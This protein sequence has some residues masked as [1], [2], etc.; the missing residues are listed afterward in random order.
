[1]HRLI[2]W[3]MA[4][5]VAIALALLAL[6]AKAD[7]TSNVA[8][9]VVATV[10]SGLT[11][12]V[13]ARLL[14]TR[15]GIGAPKAR[16]AARSTTEV[17]AAGRGGVPIAGVA[18][19]VLNVTVNG[20][21]DSGFLTVWPAGVPRPTASNVNFLPRQT[22]A[23]QAIVKVG[24]GGVI[25]VFSSTST[26]MF[27]DVTGYYPT[28]DGYRAL[29]PSRL[30]DTRP[31]ATRPGNASTT[32]VR[33]LGV[34][35]V[36]ASGVAAVV[37]NVAD[38]DPTNSGWL[39]IFPSGVPRPNASTLNYSGGQARAAMAIA[40]VGTNG[41]VDIYSSSATDLIVDVAGWIPLVS[42]YSAMTPVRVAD[43]RTGAG[44][45]GPVKVGE[46]DAP[47]RTL[48]LPLTG[49]NGIP[50]YGVSA[51]ELNI[52]VTA[53][54]YQGYSTAWPTGVRRPNASTQNFNNADTTRTVANSATVKVGA[55]GSVN[56]FLSTALQKPDTAQIFIDVVGYFR[57]PRTALAID[58][59]PL[60]NGS[61]ALVY[62]DAVAASG[63]RAPYTWSAKGLPSGLQ[64]NPTTGAISGVPTG[65][66]AADAVLTVTD[67]DGTA[68]SRTLSIAVSGGSTLQVKQV[69]AGREHT[70]AVLTNGSVKCWGS[71]R[72]GQLGDGTRNNASTPRTV[73]GLGGGAASVSAGSN[74]TCAL[75]TSGAVRCWG[76]NV[77]GQ[78][79][80]GSTSDSNIP[81]PVTGLTSGTATIS[82]GDYHSCA[83]S[84]SGAAKCWGSNADGRLGNGST[85]DS[86]VPVGVRGLTSGV[87]MISAG[88]SHTCAVVAP[89]AVKC[90]GLNDFGQVGNGGIAVPGAS[91]VSTPATVIGV[92]SSA[93][94]VSAGG[95]TSCASTADWTAW[96]WGQNGYG[97]L[98][99][100]TG[101]NS[102][103]ATR[104][105]VPSA[106][107][108]EVAVGAFHSCSLQAAGTV[109]CWGNQTALGDGLVDPDVSSGRSKAATVA[110]ATAIQGV[111]MISAGGG[112]S[113]AVTSAGTVRCW[114]S[115]SS[116]ELGNGTDEGSAV[117]VPVTGLP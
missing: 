62:R 76:Y 95:D 80:N 103:T 79:G 25:D 37:L 102:R 44:L 38:I 72:L 81:V 49:R 43:S 8:D 99:N 9:P 85:T 77:T 55:D 69:S 82:A 60:S 89:G 104:V 45:R 97:K 50:T 27:I 107:L 48:V 13:P 12:L 53:A 32:G 56:V 47:G 101:V 7:A 71:N 90:W 21:A 51:V 93:R 70:C 2:T 64:M 105:T 6:P 19:V 52:T 26:N 18:A 22:I 3:L 30:L 98:G 92:G 34:G 111:S 68:A 75:L 84:T 58:A 15:V 23:N 46:A 1:M 91:S 10:G 100:G 4:A 87:E 106:G 16:V 96:C 117:P 24:P 11:P 116:G 41:R 109:A 63:G 94:S 36:P 54:S 65:S 59:A 39:T 83:V 74:Y 35:G 73:V 33:V 113:C 61:T 67:A 112:H 57:T 14:D 108:T 86:A 78:L 114:G 17:Q 28:G 110:V 66:G 31:A 20:P 88:G 115:N 40:K 29:P 5:V 42:D